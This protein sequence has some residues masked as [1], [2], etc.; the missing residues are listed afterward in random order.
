MTCRGVRFRVFS[1]LSGLGGTPSRPRSL[2]PP[3]PVPS[4]GYV[5]LFV[6]GSLA[7]IQGYF[8]LF[9]CSGVCVRVRGARWLH[10]PLTRFVSN[11]LGCLQNVARAGRPEFKR[12]MQA[13][14]SLIKE[15]LRT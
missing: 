9:T 2:G 15:Q 5:S 7:C 1:S 6:C 13:H 3:T 14:A 4:R 12:L 8:C 11:A 10:S